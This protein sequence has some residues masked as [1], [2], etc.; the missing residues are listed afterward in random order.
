MA[1]SSAPTDFFVCTPDV[2]GAFSDRV[3]VHCNPAAPGAIAYFAVCTASD[4]VTASRYL[5]MF[6]TA[7]ATGKHLG[8]YYTAANTSGTACGCAAGDCRLADG[9]DIRP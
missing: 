2:I 9:V 8:I 1:S 4:S 7:Y 3:H 5:S 6:T